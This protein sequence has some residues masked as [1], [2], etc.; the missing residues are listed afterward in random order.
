MFLFPPGTVGNSYGCSA[1]ALDCDEPPS[2][3]PYK[4]KPLRMCRKLFVFLSPYCGTVITVPY[5]TISKRKGSGP[6]AAPYKKLIYL[7]RPR[8]FQFW[9]KYST[10][11]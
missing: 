6:Q 2:A 10:P 5:N 3:N 9:M 1:V 4:G 11:E 8:H 7:L